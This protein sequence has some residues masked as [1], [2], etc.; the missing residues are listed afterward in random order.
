MA[1]GLVVVCGPDRAPALESIAASHGLAGWV[2]A[3]RSA[4]T[5]IEAPRFRSLEEGLDQ[6]SAVA[7]LSP[8]RGLAG[9]LER[10]R[11]RGIPVALAGPPSARSDAP[12]YAPGR[13][14]HTDAHAS[15]DQL[16]KRPAFGRPVYLRLVIGGGASGLPGAWWG[17][18]E[19]LECALEL[20]DGPP[21]RLRVGAAARGGTLARRGHPRGRRR[22]LGPARGHPGA[23]PGRGCDAP[24]H[25]G[26][27]AGGRPQRRRV[28]AR[29]RGRAP[30]APPPGLARRPLDRRRLRGEAPP[31]DRPR[32][33]A[34]PC[35]GPC[36]GPPASAPWSRSASD[37]LPQLFQFR[38]HLIPHPAGRLLLIVGFCGETDED[39]A[40]T[41][42]LMEE[43]RFDSAFMFRYSERSGTRAARRQPDDVPGEVK[44]E[45]LQGIIELQEGI[46]REINE[47]MTGRE[48]EVLVEGRSRRKGK[49]GRPTW[50]GRSAQGKVT[51]FPEEAPANR[52]LRARVES[53][54][55]HTLYGRL[56]AGAG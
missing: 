17:L 7:V 23:G 48:V 35:S 50:F 27:G 55:S 4:R 20:L 13:W 1:D 30:P 39:Y 8:Y 41:R 49:D 12:E 33:P 18:L 22:G 40:L 45:R 47:A 34:R 19:A 44:A 11:R 3:G 25:R 31:G 29:R 51:V 2:R 15:V 46:S 28:G 42:E 26:P 14:R 36:A 10:C 32:R 38:P 21:A 56:L 54:T 53:A 5:S 16:R 6:A 9:D 37:R 52:L 24:G 43:I